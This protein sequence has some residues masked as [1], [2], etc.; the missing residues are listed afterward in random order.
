[1]CGISAIVSLGGAAIPD[2]RARLEHMNAL[3]AHRGPDG[4]GTWLEQG[5][6]TGM[7]HRRLA[8]VDLEHGQQPMR[9]PASGVTLVFNG[10]IYNHPELRERLGPSG[11]CTRSDTEVLL[12]A[13]LAWGEGCL[14]QLRGM[15]AF[16]L[17]DPRTALLFAARDRFGIK[18]LYF[19]ESDGL[20]YMASE[21]KAL[22]P[23][24]R[25]VETDTDALRDYLAFQFCLHGRT[26]F[27]G[28]RALEPGHVLTVQ[29]G[30]V[31]T[32]R[33]WEVWYAPDM[34]RRA[35]WLEERVAEVLDE[36]MDLHVRSDVPIGAYVSGG[37]D[38]SLVAS[39]AARRH[40]GLVAFTGRFDEGDGFDESGHAR[41]VAAHAGIT[42]HERTITPQ[43]FVDNMP[44]IAWHLDYPVAGPGAFSQFMVSELAARHRKV[45][46]GGQG[47]DEIFGG[48]TRYLIAYFEQCIKA[49]I[50]GTMHDGRFIVTYESI[51]PNLTALR[52]YKPMLQQFWRDGLFEPMD[53]RYFRLVNRAHDLGAVIRHDAIG[54]HD[55]FESFASVFHGG[56][57]RR[58]SYFDQMTHFDVKTLLPALLH[59]EDRV[60]M[61]HGLEAR[62][63]LLDHRLVELAA[64]IPA[65][66]KFTNGE[67][68][69]VLR[70]V[71][72]PHLPASITAR[73]DKM[74]FPT[75][76]AEWARG[77]LR[78]FVLDLL[79][80]DAAR[81]RPYVDNAQ[82]RAL[83][84]R[85]P[86]FG[87]GLWA[88]LSLELW[89]RQFHDVPQAF[90]AERPLRVAA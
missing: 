9:D 35:G 19:A 5:A 39:L 86:R 55:A 66:V 48:Y 1:M 75:P 78:D 79:G 23:F 38:S 60:S 80:S 74:G 41:A 31:R 85:E 12:R 89:H 37:L 67:L 30:T 18:P 40:D 61:A 68:K 83:I 69:R 53:R 58:E 88:L 64:T 2:A 33:Y 82:A 72:E 71:A 3:Q 63:P 4:A 29:H 70:R 62:V 46:L 20:L 59:V 34:S 54:E 45:V 65:D 47:G 73:T 24:L 17:W 49:A 84:E 6:V 44:R 25:T 7:A 11:F 16:V 43:D 90:R 56:N 10:E 36:S 51:I 26:L 52:Q 22:L 8:I 27:R 76:V 28:V 42:L 21:A 77:P 81:Q 50:D 87:R 57:V 13:Y 14:E 15:F 32:R